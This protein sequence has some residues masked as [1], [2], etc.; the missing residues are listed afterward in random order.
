MLAMTTMTRRHVLKW[1]AVASGVAAAGVASGTLLIELIK[2]AT[3]TTPSQPSGGM[4]MMGSASS[5]DMSSYMDLFNR[6]DEITRSVAAIPGGI[7]TTTES[8]APDLAAQIQAHVR[9]MYQHL[10]AGSEVTCMSPTL[11]TLFRNASGYR[12]EFAL[13]AKGVAVSETSTDP[14]LVSAIRA[15]ANEVSGFVRDGMPAMMSGMM[16]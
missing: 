15:H 11:P 14:V 5:A 7:R 10:S 16:G 13:T 2:S 1:V 12:R 4:G 8:D 9:S 3:A 6:H